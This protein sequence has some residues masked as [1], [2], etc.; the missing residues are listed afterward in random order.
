MSKL[1]PFALFT[2]DRLEFKAPPADIFEDLLGYSGTQRFVGF[3]YTGHALCIEDGQLHEIGERRPWSIW[4]R[5]LGP[6]V[7][8][9][10]CFGYEGRE[11]EHMLILDRISRVLYVAPV[12]AG[13]DVL[14]LQIPRLPKTAEEFLSR[15][16]WGDKDD[17]PTEIL[18][19]TSSAGDLEARIEMKDGIDRLMKWVARG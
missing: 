19:S 16:N 14:K 3:Y 8:R 10:Y 9:Y 6:A 1:I 5:T 2:F 15:A 13:Q 18:F 4:Y 7:L 12:R 17:E 11:P